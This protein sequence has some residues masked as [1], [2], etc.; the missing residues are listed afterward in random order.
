LNQVPSLL[1]SECAHIAKKQMRPGWMTS[2]R[3]RI[4]SGGLLLSGAAVGYAH[5]KYSQLG[6]WRHSMIEAYLL[7]NASPF[8]GSSE[9][10]PNIT[11][12]ETATRSNSTG[13]ELQFAS[14]PREK[15]NAQLRNAK[16]N[17]VLLGPQGSGKSVLAYAQD[18]TNI[19]DLSHVS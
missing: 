13:H 9:S 4:L 2:R 7:D 12:T 10:D 5:Y 14:L 6:E 17:V 16:G 19:L 3:I 11:E 18:S 8:G 15:L 1:W